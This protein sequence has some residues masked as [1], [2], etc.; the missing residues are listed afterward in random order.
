MLPVFLL[1][2]PEI[3]RRL[4]IYRYNKLGDARNRAKEMGHMQGVL[5]PWRTI[6]GT[7]CSSY[8]PSG[9]AQY[10]ISGDIAYSYIQYF[11]ATGDFQF[12]KEYGT[13]LLI[14]TARLWVD[15]GHYHNGK[16]KIDAVTGPDEYTCVINNNYYTNVI[17]KYNLLWANKA[18]KL[19]EEKDYEAFSA[20]TDRL[21]LSEDEMDGWNKAAEAMY[22]P[23]DEK[24]KI[25]P[26]DDTFLQKAVWDFENTPTEN[27]PLLLHYHPLTLYRYQVCK[28]A[29]TVLV[30]FLLE[31]EQDFT[32]I[33]NSYDYYEK[34]TTHDSSLSSCIFSIMA[35]KIGYH[36]KAYDY[37]IETGRLDLDNTH[38]NTKDGL[39]MANMGGTWMAIVFGFAGLRIKETGLSL[40]PKIP[41]QWQRLA[42]RVQYQNR[43]LE[44]V[45]EKQQVKV[46]LL[47]GETL[48]LKVY[49]QE[50]LLQLQQ[51]VVMK[52]QPQAFI[53]DLDGVI[54]DTAEF[55]FLAWRQLAEKLKIPFHRKFNEELK[56]ISRMESLEKILLYGGRQNDF[57]EKEKEE[58]AAEKNEKYMK[59]I[60][61]LTPN[62]ILPGIRPF[63]DLC[64]KNRFKLAI[65]S[66]SKNAG[67]V[68]KALGLT[69]DFDV[70]VDAKTIQN[71]KPDPEIF[72]T[73]A[74]LLNVEARF[75]IGIE[76][77]MAGIKAIKAAGMYAVAVGKKEAFEKADYVVEKTNE[78]VLEE[79]IKHY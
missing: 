75:C 19:I 52:K 9:S 16:F 4:L 37:F 35:S 60:E 40:D 2:K 28:Q 66:A 17:A 45:I 27:Y 72:L 1:I 36:E 25:N 46:T 10:H 38:G 58:L 73:A 65:A 6:T 77:A 63:I 32:T 50:A 24:L 57:I 71:G 5:F 67:T 39:H 53:F 79:I 78:L 22:L 55:H 31:D 47:E 21:M 74:K 7:E 8:F 12:L 29:D 64:K 69:N 48:P 59:L 14:E 43:K 3:A 41:K 15:V 76:D 51:T 62:D 56:G 34:I 44:V 11:L 42:F 23:Y 26:Q 20:L 70:I 13:E 68:I 61:T 30:H 33:K 54:T 49:G 18:C